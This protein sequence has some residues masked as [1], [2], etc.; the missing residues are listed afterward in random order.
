MTG[1]FE[2]DFYFLFDLFKKNIKFSFSKY[3]DGEYA[4]L[5][6]RRI[7]NCDGWTFIPDADAIYRKELLDSFT[8]KDDGYYVGISC[9]CCVDMND[10]LWMRKFV[11]ADSN[12]L[13]WANIFVNGN[14]DKFLQNFVPEFK[15]HDIILIASENATINEL[16][17]KIEKHIPVTSVAWKDN[18]NLVEEL[19]KE[20]YKE[21][22][23]LFCAG[24]LGNMLAAKMW[25]YNK[26][27]TYL[28][29]GSTLNPWL[30]GYNRG[31][32]MGSPTRNKICIW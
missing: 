7:T 21:K 5:A 26:N 28:D 10:V 9:P 15:N 8:Y 23:F 18:F 30:V 1:N 17:F 32:L 11:G 6:N 31:Y 27:N 3:A 24:P 13:T 19:P 22:V 25:K 2:K 16:P 4:I 14:Y 29:I 20:D 12:H